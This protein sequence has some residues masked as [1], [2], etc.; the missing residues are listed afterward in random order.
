MLYEVITTSPD[1][2]TFMNHLLRFYEDNQQVW[3]VTGF[4]NP[5]NIYK[6]Y[7]YDAY[8]IYRVG[9]WGWATWIDRWE[10]AYNFV[11]CMLYEVI[12][13]MQTAKMTIII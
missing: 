4:N 11:L 12:T 10:K 13:N 9:S 2:L 3:S 5:F 7:G 1:F 8:A 6:E